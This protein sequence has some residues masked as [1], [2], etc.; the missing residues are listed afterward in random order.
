MRLFHQL[1]ALLLLV[2]GCPAEA[3]P[4]GGAARAEPGDLAADGVTE[5]HWTFTGPTSVAFDWRGPA[6]PL[7]Y[8]VG[9]Q[10]P[11]QVAPHAPAPLPMSSPGPF[12]EAAIEGLAPDTVYHYS[13]GG[14]ATVGAG[15]HTFH[16]PPSAAKSD[17]VV[18][19]VGDLGASS[20]WPHAARI[21]QLIAETRPA[22]VLVL[23]DISYS[24]EG[25]ATA[26]AVDR[27]FDD[28]M[29]WS[30][31]AAYLPVWGN[32]EWE[33]PARDD[34]RN[35]KGRFALPNPAASPGA[36]AAGCCG[37]DWYW[38]DHGNVR[39]IAYPEPYTR[40]TWADWGARAEPIFAA[41]QADPRIVFIVTAGH[42]PAF[43]SGHH[44]GEEQLRRLL[45]H[46]GRRFPK[47]VLNLNGHNHDYERTRPRKGVVHVTVGTGGGALEHAPT[48]CRWN[49]CTPPTWT[50]RRAIHHAFLRLRFTA[51]LI[52]GTAVC[53][54]AS[55]GYDDVACG[56]GEALDTFSITPR[57]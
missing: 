1:P 39:F 30:R 37:E 2:L 44:P 51:A 57:R 13:V 41:A 31:D 21:H 20:Q 27:H 16:T 43:A 50:A 48:A 47:Y 32:H 17:F 24:D 36:P 9:S 54:P 38:F 5:L 55:P 15:D 35:Y 25:S 12:Q 28:A 52:E 14:R 3:A 6:A 11:R 33:S 56:E 4:D 46:F 34:L 29:V 7:R 53:G 19:T 8:W 45:N 18:A 42:R 23:G 40:A 49:D 10:P 26:A 22:F